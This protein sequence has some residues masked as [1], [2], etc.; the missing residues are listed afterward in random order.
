MRFRVMIM[1]DKASGVGTGCWG[2]FSVPD[3]IALTNKLGYGP[4]MRVVEAE[5]SDLLADM[6]REIRSAG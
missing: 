1:E 2:Q 3:E 4:M 5:L 6:M